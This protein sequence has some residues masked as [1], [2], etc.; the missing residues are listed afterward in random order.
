MYSII[1][2]WLFLLTVLTIFGFIMLLIKRE[3]TEYTP[4]KTKYGMLSHEHMSLLFDTHDD[5]YLLND[6]DQ[7]ILYVCRDVETKNE[8]E[9]GTEYLGYVAHAFPIN[10]R[11][12][13]NYWFSEERHNIFYRA[14]APCLDNV[15]IYRVG[16][17]TEVARKV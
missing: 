11:E 17:A 4:A 1:E 7:D 16:Y 2:V 9:F 13:A 5:L 6:M 14:C 10:L 3:T 15:E 8:W 12:E